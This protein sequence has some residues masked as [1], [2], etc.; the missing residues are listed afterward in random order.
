M[1]IFSVSQGRDPVVDLLSTKLAIQKLESSNSDYDIATGVYKGKSETSFIT[2]NKEVALELAKLNNQ[3]S[4][5]ELGAKGYW[6]LIDTFTGK[7]LDYFK[8]IKWMPE[9]VALKYDNY[10]LFHGEYYVGVK[11]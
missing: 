6:Y 2:T 8:T 10:T 7:Q 4:Y 11:A 5:L 9:D 1:I 3:E